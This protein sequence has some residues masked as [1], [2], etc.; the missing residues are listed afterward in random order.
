M[1]SFQRGMQILKNWYGVHIHTVLEGLAYPCETGYADF[2][3]VYE[4]A[5][6]KSES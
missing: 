2:I 1:G 6:L 5:H 4:T 3:R